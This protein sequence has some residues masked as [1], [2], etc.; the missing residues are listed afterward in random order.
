MSK[1]IPLTQGIFSIVDD[2]DFDRLA[3][4]EWYA[5]WDNGSHSFYA[6][7]HHILEGTYQMSRVIMAAPVGLVPD[8][9]NHDTLDNRKSNL[10]LVTIAQN[11]LNK[12]VQR[13]KIVPY[14]GVFLQR[15][16]YRARITVDGRCINIG[17]FATAEDAALAYLESAVKYHGEYRYQERELCQ[18]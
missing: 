5:R 12:I 11:N 2:D 1:Q 8:H 18:L 9:I 4:W 3:S 7:T 17:C 14:K 16:R 15:D 10:R 6:S 13:G